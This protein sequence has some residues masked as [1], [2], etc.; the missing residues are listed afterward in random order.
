MT[1]ITPRQQRDIRDALVERMTPLE[2]VDCVDEWISDNN[3]D[4]LTF[5]SA[6]EFL[7]YLA[8]LPVERTPALAHI[9]MDATRI[10]V[11]SAKG[12]CH[13]C[14]E[15]V[16]AGQGHKALVNSAW[17]FFHKVDDC[18]AVTVVSEV[19]YDTELRNR[20][21]LFVASLTRLEPPILP[22]EALFNLSSARDFDLGFDLKLP[23]LGYQKSAVEY[24]RRTRKA[25]VCQ[26]MGLGKTPIGIAVAH[27]AVQEGH[28]VAI[29]VPPNLRYQWMSELKR[30]APWL[31]VGTISGRKV[32][33]LP[34]CD[35]LVIPD[36]IVE[37]WQNVIAGK[38]TSLIV[39]EAHRFKTEK[40]GRTKALTY[41]ANSIPQNGYCALLSGTII[42]NRPSEFIAPL[43]IIGRLDPVF[44]TKKQFQIRYCDYQ[45]VN[46]FPNMNG[47]SN[48]AELN[49]ILRSTCYTRTRKVDVLEDLPPKRRAQLDVELPATAMKKYRDAEDN[50][51]EWVQET[52]GDD[53]F[54]AAS[55]A[56]VITEINKLRQ[57]LGEA[58]VDSAVAHIQSLLDSGEQVIAFA[59]HTSVIKAI[60]EKF[61]DIGVVSVVGGMTAEAK[62]KA[63]QAFTSGEARLFVGQFDAA[64]VGLNLQCASHVVMVEMPWSPSIG[65]QAEDR[66][67][68]Y[69]VQNPVV[70]W[71]LTAI[72]PEMP[73][74][75]LR[76]WQILN[77]KQE[78]I[79]AC[80]D[81][82][83][84]DMNAEAGSVTALLLSD[85][86]GV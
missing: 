7:D 3:L 76:M 73:T 44:G 23:M 45:M 8:M 56:P 37:A 70:A 39:D 21:D 72:D 13:L 86:M 33:K 55:K 5:K 53:A 64:G 17:R 48:V 35:V 15:P 67:W 54:K 49:Q 50:F 41:I 62:D 58:K 66:A 83:A 4:R 60:K 46:G 71:W 12:V 9:P 75:D 61:S 82:W 20:L 26:D 28:K 51:L 42:P 52:Y 40:S 65:S 6:S 74:I 59:Y 2:M 77:Q 22:D 79:S 25:L 31:K 69:G 19:S 38:Y 81:G 34:K 85:M 84:E 80:L 11:N 47:A 29:F 27:M 32:G 68:R 57:L 24:V 16:S 1:G 63:V 10:M 30:F 78:T 43:K 18:S 14:H 36:S